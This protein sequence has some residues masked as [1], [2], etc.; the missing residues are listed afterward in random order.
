MLRCPFLLAAIVAVS[1]NQFATGSAAEPAA[2]QPKIARRAGS[3]WPVFLGPTG[4]SKSSETGLKTPW[5]A[6]G[7]PLVW[8]AEIAGGYAAPA[9]SA[10]RLFLFDRESDHNRLRA[11]ESETGRPL[12]EFTYPTEYRDLYG[13]DGGPRC[14]PVVDGDRVYLFGPEGMLHCLDVAAGR[15]LWKVDTAE[16]F[17]VVQNFFGVGSTPVVERDLL[18]VQVGGSPPESRRAPPGQLD[19]VVGAGSG[20]V[21]FD[22]L[23]GKVKYQITDQLASYAS[24]VLATIQGRRWCFMFARGGLVGFEPASGKIDFQ[25]PWRAPILES[26]N[27]SNP[28]VVCD[29]V[30]ISETYGP[31]SALLKVRPGGYDVVWSDAKQRREKAMQTH[32]NTPIHHQG[33]LYGSSGRHEGN[34]E[35]RCI[36]LATG[37]ILWSEPGLRRAS[38]LEVD[39]HFVCLSED[40]MLRLIKINPEKYELV[41]TAI[42][43]DAA[44]AAGTLGLGARRLLKQPAWAA[45]VLSHGLLY[46]RGRDRLVC[47]ELIPAK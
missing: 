41:S 43:A 34:A 22:K 6:A 11:L 1:A 8:Q 25:F 28:V 7:P 45:P 39:G 35:L 32:W 27:A 10:G 18:I 31:G 2:A 44:P 42:L 40:G 14:A 3:D 16:Q 37:K 46:V 23:T 17:G 13:Y 12:W 24:P 9:I 5:S 26:V 19:Q 20:I 30:F 33:Y 21:A 4:D 38:L 15:L 36:E 29:L 47:V